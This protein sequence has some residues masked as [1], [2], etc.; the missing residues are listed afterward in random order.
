MAQSLLPHEQFGEHCTAWCRYRDAV[1]DREPEWTDVARIT[2]S[3]QCLADARRLRVVRQ[4]GYINNEELPYLED[5]YQTVRILDANGAVVLTLGGYVH[6]DDVA[7]GRWD[8]RYLE[9][10]EVVDEQHIRIEL[11]VG[12]ECLPDY[13]EFW[14]EHGKP[15]DFSDPYGEST[16]ASFSICIRR[17]DVVDEFHREPQWERYEQNSKERARIRCNVIREELMKNRWCT[18]RV[19]EFFE[20]GGKDIECM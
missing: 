3:F 2:A 16:F 9:A 19:V 18:K 11:M 7:M 1:L 6:G 20:A 10:T 8:E 17:E 4:S 14:D 13:P 12:A 5:H 15:V